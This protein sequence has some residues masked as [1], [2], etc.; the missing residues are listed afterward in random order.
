MAFLATRG[1]ICH[2]SYRSAGRDNRFCGKYEL[3]C[4]LEL[5]IM[6]IGFVGAVVSFLKRLPREERAMTNR[7]GKR[8]RHLYRATVSNIAL[9]EVLELNFVIVD[10]QLQ[11]K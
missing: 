4:Q 3:L 7:L 2:G 11:E 1:P 10:Q 6:I 5:I 8:L 9:V